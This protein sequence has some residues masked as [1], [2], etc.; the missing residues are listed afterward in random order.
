[1]AKTWKNA[2]IQFGFFAFVV[3]FAEIIY[4]IG[5]RQ[6]HYPTGVSVA[7]AFVATLAVGTPIWVKYI[8]KYSG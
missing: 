3:I 6:W 4:Q 7:F 1:M 2:I 5:V 8:K